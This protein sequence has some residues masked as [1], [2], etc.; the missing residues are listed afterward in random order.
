MSFSA[1]LSKFCKT[2][3]PE[4]TNRIVRAV[5]IEIANRVVL[6]SPVG[7]AQYW[8]SP[9]PA[10]YVGG[11]FRGNWQY[12][13]GMPPGGTIERVDK[14]GRETLGALQSALALGSLAGVHWIANNLPYAERIESGWSGQA[15]QGVVALTELEF[16]QIVKRVIG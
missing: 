13:F 1:D 15:P 11:R 6:R 9:A 5:V 8:Q 4:K 16:P 14:S 2:E 3:A 10:G 7:D 12:G